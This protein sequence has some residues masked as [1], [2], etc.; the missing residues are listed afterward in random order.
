M[1][2]EWDHVCNRSK[3]TRKDTP[4]HMWKKLLYVE[5][6]GRCLLDSDWPAF[7]KYLE[8]V[9]G[10]TVQP[11]AMGDRSP[12]IPQP[13]LKHTRTHKDVHSYLRSLRAFTAAAELNGSILHTRAHTHTQSLKSRFWTRRWYA[14][15]HSPWMTFH[16]TSVLLQP[17]RGQLGL[18]H[19]SWKIDASF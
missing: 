9:E 11:V 5:R 2:L 14:P 18:S 6:V 12:L 1:S 16:L 10:S 15:P 19:H 4:R 3:H 13:L 7:C 17:I 8:E